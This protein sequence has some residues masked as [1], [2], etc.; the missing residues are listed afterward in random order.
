MEIDFSKLSDQDMAILMVSNPEDSL[1]FGHDKRGMIPVS[2]AEML[3]K[4]YFKMEGKSRK[5]LTSDQFV[6][7]PKIE[8]IFVDILF[9]ILDNSYCTDNVVDETAKGKENESIGRQ[10]TTLPYSH[11]SVSSGMSPPDVEKTNKHTPNIVVDSIHIS[12]SPSPISLEVFTPEVLSSSRKSGQ[13]V[14]SPPE[15]PQSSLTPSI[16]EELTTPLF[17]EHLVRSELMSGG[18]N[19][20]SHHSEIDGEEGEEGREKQKDLS[21]LSSVGV[22][23]SSISDLYSR[24]SSSLA[25]SVSVSC[26]CNQMIGKT[27]TRDPCTSTR[28]IEV[29]CSNCRSMPL[30]VEEKSILSNVNVSM[31][32]IQRIFQN[33]DDLQHGNSSCFSLVE[34]S[35]HVHRTF[36]ISFHSVSSLSQLIVGCIPPIILKEERQKEISHQSCVDSSQIIGESI[37]KSIEK[38][39]KYQFDI[40]T[41]VAASVICEGY[42][43]SNGWSLNNSSSRP[44]SSF[45]TKS[46]TQPRG[47]QYISIMENDNKGEGERDEE[48]KGEGFSESFGCSSTDSIHSDVCEKD[49][50]SSSD[51]A[52]LSSRSN[53]LSRAS[54]LSAQTTQTGLTP[55]F[56]PSIPS[57]ALDTHLSVPIIPRSQTGYQDSTPPLS[58]PSTKTLSLMTDVDQFPSSVSIEGKSGRNEE[59]IPLGKRRISSLKKEDLDSKTS[60]I[61]DS[62]G[63]ITTEQPVFMTECEVFFILFLESLSLK[64][65][66]KWFSCL[67]LDS[68][69]AEKAFLFSI[70]QSDVGNMSCIIRVS[71]RFIHKDLPRNVVRAFDRGWSRRGDTYMREGRRSL[72]RSLSSNI[73]IIPQVDEIQPHREFGED[74]FRRKESVLPHEKQGFSY[75]HTGLRI[76]GDE[77]LS[78]PR[79]AQLKHFDSS[80]SKASSGSAFGRASRLLAHVG[81]GEIDEKLQDTSSFAIDK[82]DGLGEF[83]G[84]FDID[85]WE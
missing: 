56:P 30:F 54:L 71:T 19:D 21:K 16:L 69:E 6:L 68:V 49:D 82:D 4:R 40:V 35:S 59:S 33:S 10:S 63:V 37:S 77:Q 64:S 38:E 65:N 74:P 46:I 8:S 47:S 1:F 81:S 29:C 66:M 75:R 9:H 85:I 62:Q 7:H 70:S 55:V 76:S 78:P 18:K 43:I 15:F 52:L 45:P 58:I 84:D 60:L 80:Q 53:S 13:S 42:G 2:F 72:N 73:S 83:G 12:H 44:S 28:I 14:A 24:S 17:D 67:F 36:D 26:G 20:L 57:Q 50:K 22:G 31:E 51:S 23:A 11:S 48:E 25:S 79:Q 32:S 34:A 27:L 41:C 39:Y 61:S 5:S 3:L